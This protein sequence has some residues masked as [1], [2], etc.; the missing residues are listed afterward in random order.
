MLQ[1]APVDLFSDSMAS[2]SGLVL[3]KDSLELPGQFLIQQ[4][5]RLLLQSGCRVR[6][7]PGELSAPP[8]PPTD[9]RHMPAQQV[10]LVALQQSVENYKFVLRRMVRT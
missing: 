6:C 9:C 3:Y 5:L 7:R 1:Q 10:L 2:T 8:A 4:H